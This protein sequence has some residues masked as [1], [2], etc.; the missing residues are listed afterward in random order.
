MEFF[1]HVRMGLVMI[2]L[3]IVNKNH[4]DVKY[5]VILVFVIYDL[6][7]FAKYIFGYQPI[8]QLLFVVSEVLLFLLFVLFLFWPQHIAFYNLDFYFILATIAI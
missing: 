6:F 3:N 5:G 2:F 4:P 1:N 7:Y 8:E